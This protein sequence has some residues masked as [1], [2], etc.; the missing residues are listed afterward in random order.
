MLVLAE[1]IQHLRHG[2]AIDHAAGNT[3]LGENLNHL[4]FFM[5]GEL[6]TPR[7]L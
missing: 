4:Q 6:S 7:F 1:V 3:F 2:G 5:T